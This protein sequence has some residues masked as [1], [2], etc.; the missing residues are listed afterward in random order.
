MQSFNKLLSLTLDIG[1]EMLESG[2]EIR[3]VENTVERI[4]LAYGGLRVQVFAISSLLL[5]S[6][7]DESG[8]YYIQQRRI[9]RGRCDMLRL[10]LM[11]A[12]S[13]KVCAYTPSSD[14]FENMIADARRGRYYHPYIVLAASALTSGVFALLFGGGIFE[15]IYSSFIGV[16]VFY[17]DK[18][19]DFDIN[20]AIKTGFAAF[21]GG[22]FSC[23]LSRSIPSINTASVILAT[24][25]MLV[26]GIAFGNSL[27]NLLFGDFLSGVIDFVRSFLTAFMMAVGYILSLI[28]FRVQF[29]AKEAAILPIVAAITTVIGVTCFAVLFEVRPRHLFS[30]AFGG[31]CTY[32]VEQ[33]CLSFNLSLL[34]GAFLASCTAALFSEIFARIEKAP[35]TVFLLPCLIPILPG[36]S[37]YNSLNSLVIGNTEVAFNHLLSSA[38]VAAGLAL[39]I[40]VVSVA[41]GISAE[42]IARVKNRRKIAKIVDIFKKI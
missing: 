28:L 7:Y 35:T 42:I 29:S 30:I 31:L 24:A 10:E 40:S 2:A 13:R 33:L 5:V 32:T 27:R 14:E 20:H 4:C 6:L 1:Q 38:S 39:G 17:I 3:R 34:F 22:T 26:P 21:L 9:R 23:I 18:K 37:L 36:I 15:A 8:N 11:N 41:V 19:S 16:I 25:V 12:V